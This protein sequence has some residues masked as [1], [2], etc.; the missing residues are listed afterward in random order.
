MLAQ[1]EHDYA[2][3][4]AAFSTALDGVAEG[5]YLLYG[6]ENYGFVSSILIPFSTA[7]NIQYKQAEGRGL[8]E[9]ELFKVRNSI[10]KNIKAKDLRDTWISEDE[11]TN[12]SYEKDGKIYFF[13]DNFAENSK[14]EP[15]KHY[16]GNYAYNEEELDIN[17]FI[18]VFE[19]YIVEESGAIIA[20]QWTNPNFYTETNF[21]K[22][23]GKVD[24]S[25]FTYYT[26]KV[27]FAETPKASDFLNRESQQ[28][29]A[30]SAVNEL[31]FAYSTDPGSLNSYMGYAI[32]PYTTSFVKEYE[33]AAQKVVEKGVGAYAVSVNQYGWHIVYCTFKFDGGEVYGGVNMPATHEDP[34]VETWAK[35]MEVEGSFANLFYE[36]IKETAYNN[37]ATEEQNRAIRE[38][39]VNE[40]VTRF[41]KAYKDL[42]EMDKQ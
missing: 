13:E 9:N 12:Y 19:S 34:N 6:L 28:Y 5:S 33:Y 10:A 37:H 41:T 8:T 4:Y 7:Q 11:H 15:L 40:C 2:N 3:D 30:L 36:T 14:Y 21:K 20:N 27:E 39:D 25:K 29:K 16:A 22:A 23:D 26:G 31:L 17:E 18:N 32:S 1:Q 24:Y 42:L 35:Q 38:Y